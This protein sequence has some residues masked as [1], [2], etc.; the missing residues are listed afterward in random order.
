M[1][2]RFLTSEHA[3]SVLVDIRKVNPKILVDIR[4]ATSNNF[5]GFQ[6]YSLPLCYVHKDLAKA[7]NSVQHE[8]EK[9]GLGLKVYDGFRPISVQQIMWENIQDPRYVSNPSEYMGS[10]LRGAAVD[11][12]LV[13]KHGEELEM[14]SGF[15]EFTERAHLEYMQGSKSALEN[16]E[17][18]QT[19]MKK[20]GLLP[21]DT[22]WWHFSLQDWQDDDKYPALDIS[23]EELIK[24]L[25]Y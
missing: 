23:F 7:V 10:H 1:K 24:L 14:P 6:I 13:D 12:T 17:I 5:L 18:L 2:N 20:Q 15:D 11:V 19:A 3:A 8:L 9:I 25:A 21:I 22:E 4:Y 16:R